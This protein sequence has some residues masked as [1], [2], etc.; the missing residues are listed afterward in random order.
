MSL[1]DD[2]AYAMTPLKLLTLPLGV[3][4]LQKYNIFSLVRCIVCIFSLTVLMVVLFL[5]INFGSGDAYVKLDGLMVMFCAVL[6]V[7]KLLSFRIYADNLVRNFSSAINDYFAINTEEKR[8]IIRR[9]A[10]MGRMFCY[11]I[12]FFAY[13]ASSIFVL[14]PML[15]DNNDVQVNVSIKNQASDLP[16]PLTWVL[17]N[18][19]LSTSL[20]LLISMVQCILLVL[21]STSCCGC[22]ILFLAITLHVCGQ[23]ELLKIEF[24][25]YGIKNKD[26]NDDFSKL[27]SRHHY[28]IEHVK[29]LVNVIS[30]VLLV[31]MLFSCL[32]ICLIGFQLI[33]ALKSHDVV[34]I[35]KTI[36]VLSGLLLQLFFYSFVGDYLKCQMG[37]I[38]YSIY[39]CN[40][41]CLPMKLM[42]NVLFIIMRSQHPVQLLAGRFFVVNIETFMAILKSSLSYLS[43]LRVMLDA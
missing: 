7:L 43:V 21:N 9:H 13:L 3:W 15:T 14:A 12:I 30:F 5:E 6:S 2:L 36:L 40:W 35:T 39:S 33:L 17:G 20:Y 18:F 37:E 38:A 24:I 27:A 41:Y 16:V 23:I 31:Q 26:I 42:R 19:N 8:M 4:P 11:S 25:N 34:M 1:N 32:I 10:F 22:D 28:L 29:L